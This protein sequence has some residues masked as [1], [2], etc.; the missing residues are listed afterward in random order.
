MKQMIVKLL[1]VVVW[2]GFI[3]N[4][5]IPQAIFNT[6]DSDS[7]IKVYCISNGLINATDEQIAEYKIA[8]ETVHTYALHIVAQAK[9]KI[10]NG[11]KYSADNY[12]SDLRNIYSVCDSIVGLKNYCNQEVTQ[13][14]DVSYSQQR[15]SHSFYT[16]DEIDSAREKYFKEDVLRERESATTPI[17]WLAVLAWFVRCYLYSLP[18]AFILFLTWLY[19]E[20]DYTKLQLRSPFSFAISLLMYP[21]VI[22]A[23]IRKWWI[24]SGRLLHAEVE[25]RR[26]REVFFSLLSKDEIATIKK[27]ANSKLSLSDFKKGLSEQGLKP[28]HA[29]LP[30]LLFTLCINYIPQST[31]STA[32]VENDVRNTIYQV[33]NNYDYFSLNKVVTL[34]DHSTTHICTESQILHSVFSWYEEP[35]TLSININ[36]P[37]CSFIHLCR[38]Y[39]RGI[40]HIPING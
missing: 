8:N 4:L 36:Y 20:S 38:G 29:Y 27:F 25:I 37:C 1:K 19:Q 16:Q 40:A 3:W 24:T 34:S 26:T 21:I 28:R 15:Q 33:T 18:F 12:F 30:V 5:H 13:L 14:F 23:S 10:A 2:C 39:L 9:H 11:Q 7:K 32:V 17:D 6:R 35:P 31:K 22:G